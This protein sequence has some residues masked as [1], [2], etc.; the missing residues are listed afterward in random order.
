MV[1]VPGAFHVF[2]LFFFSWFNDFSKDIYR[3]DKH[4]QKNGGAPLLGLAKSK[5]NLELSLQVI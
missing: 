4:Q 5:Y 1:D 3:I 2:C